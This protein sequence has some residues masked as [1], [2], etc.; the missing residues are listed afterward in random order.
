MIAAAFLLCSELGRVAT[1][2][3]SPPACHYQGGSYSAGA[4]IRMGRFEM[5]CQIVDGM[6]K[7]ARG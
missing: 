3:D 2:P 6:P 5:E 7:W 4:V 1:A